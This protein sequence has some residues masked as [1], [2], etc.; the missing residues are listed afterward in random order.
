MKSPQSGSAET[1]VTIASRSMG[2]APLRSLEPAKHLEVDLTETQFSG[3]RLHRSHEDVAH[4]TGFPFSD[5]KTRPS[6]CSAI[7]RHAFSRTVAGCFR[8]E[9]RQRVRGPPGPS[10]FG[11]SSLS[12][13][14]RKTRHLG[15]LRRPT[16]NAGT[17]ANP[18]SSTAVSR[19]P[20]RLSG[21]TSSSR[22]R[23]SVSSAALPAWAVPWVPGCRT[24]F[25]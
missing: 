12:Y 5:G 24:G 16:P 11:G 10:C 22:R 2:P 20:S 21:M 14:H 9:C 4:P 7:S 13:R 19:L 1:I 23:C 18:R 25:S 6:G 15:C 3:L 8:K 17:P